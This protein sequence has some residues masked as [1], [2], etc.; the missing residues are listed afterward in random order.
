MISVAKF[1]RCSNKYWYVRYWIGGQRVDE[2]A[3]TKSESV[4]ESYRIRREMEINAGIYPIR[5][6]QVK[7]VIPAYAAAFPPQVSAKHRHEVSR[8]LKNFL[9]ICGRKRADGSY[10]LQ[11]QQM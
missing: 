5:H 8:A 2:S 1:Q 11:T 4:A 7:A 9:Q 6:A 3:R 10:G